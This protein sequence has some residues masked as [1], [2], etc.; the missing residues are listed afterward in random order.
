MAIFRIQLLF[1]ISSVGIS[2]FTHTVSFKYNTPS[3][4]QNQTN[5]TK[6]LTLDLVAGQTNI[7]VNATKVAVEESPREPSIAVD[8]NRVKLN[9]ADKETV[10]IPYRSVNADK[11]IAVGGWFVW[12]KIAG[13]NAKNK[14]ANKSNAFFIIK[15][16]RH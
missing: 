14:N 3:N 12:E 10:K 1:P 16:L 11:V 8:I 9:L 4:R 13:V 5:R 6:E 15:F 7:V 2:D